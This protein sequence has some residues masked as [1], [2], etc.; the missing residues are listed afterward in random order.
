[1]KKEEVIALGIGIISAGV[2]AGLLIHRAIAIPRVPPPPPE[3]SVEIKEFEL[4]SR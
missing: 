2:L 1:M 3:R 4:I